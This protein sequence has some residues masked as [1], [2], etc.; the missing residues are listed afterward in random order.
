MALLNI[1]DL[2]FT[3]P[4][5]DNTAISNID[6][7]INTGELVTVAGPTGSGKTTLLRLLKPELR[8]NG[9]LTG[10]ITLDGADISL[11][12]SAESAR[13]IGYVAQHPEEQIVTDRVWHELAFLSENLG[14]PQAEIARRAAETAAYFGI[15][16]WYERSTAE[17][18]GGQK[19]L[20]N[21]AAVMTA[22]PSL[23]ILD[24]PTAQLDP[25]TA[26]RFLEL[27]R[28]LC[29]ETGLTVIITEH[30]LEEL[31]PLSDRLVLLDRGRMVYDS[32]PRNAAN[33]S[34]ICLRYST[35]AA[36][37]FAA[38]SAGGSAPLTVSEGK[39]FISKYEPRDI[40]P[41]HE[42]EEPAA[43]LALE[44]SSVYFRYTRNDSDVLRDLSLS[45]KRGEILSVI[46]SN[47]AGKSTA[48]AAASGLKKPYSG[49][50][51]L[52]GR[53][54]KSYRKE[55]LYH[56]NI[57]LLPQD[58]ESVFIYPTVREE[59]RDCEKARELLSFDFEP[60]LDRHPYD[61]S[62]GERQMLALCKALA[63]GPRLLI[64]DEPSK[65]LDPVTKDNLASIIREIKR[66]GVT[67]LMVSHD[68]E[69]AALCAD[70][71]ALFFNGSIASVASTADFMRDNRFYTT[72]AARITRGVCRGGY[73]VERAAD[74]LF[75]G[76]CV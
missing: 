53:E 55:E 70:R 57:S 38:S 60:L 24:E 22:D 48:V 71:C 12:T 36:R 29:R 13:R 50:V 49:K 56:R 40:M 59:L 33:S 20:L 1:K 15:E 61:L 35:A 73:T 76:E 17:L 51:K 42:N 47:G 74:I 32:A 65:G 10:S 6:L 52:F 39:S 8:Q 11:M 44:L 37:L 19:Q 63:T 46:G 9:A 68:I 21:L 23:L 67:V 30:R 26:I 16:A 14:L 4:G 54:L 5:M 41:E 64:L 69:F 75:G 45:V 62:G 7:S 18:S 27:L 43:D 2:S 31:L 34:G 66:S 3:Y 25:V 72:A 28:R 58:V